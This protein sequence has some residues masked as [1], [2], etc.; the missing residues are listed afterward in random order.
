MS[1]RVTWERCPRCRGRAAV[2]W[3]AVPWSATQ[4][5]AEVP[6]EFDCPAG[7]SV[8]SGEL[9]RLIPPPDGSRA[10]DERSV[11]DRPADL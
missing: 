10:D 8:R 1:D 5:A 9:L 3:D 11:V 6:V 7:C 2:G 4:P